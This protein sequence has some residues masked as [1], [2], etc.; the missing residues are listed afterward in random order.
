MV[1]R[2]EAIDLFRSD[3]LLGIGMAADA[4]QFSGNRFGRPHE[5]HAPGSNRTLRHRSPLRR[6]GVLREGHAPLGLDGLETVCAIGGGSREQHANR[7]RPPFARQGAQEG[8]NGE[9]LCAGRK[10]RSKEEGILCKHERGIGGKDIHL[11]GLGMHAIPD[12]AH[13]HG[14]H[15]S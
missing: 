15:A 2:Q 5:I 8:I 11:V 10:Q 1:T 12:F 3:D 13:G 6:G 4:G 14:G 9:A 7:V